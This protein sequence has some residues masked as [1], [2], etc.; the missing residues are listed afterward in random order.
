MNK[1]QMIKKVDNIIN[2]LQKEGFE[3]FS[4]MYGS[5]DERKNNF[6]Q[7]FINDENNDKCNMDTAIIQDGDFYYIRHMGYLLAE[8]FG[9]DL[10][11]F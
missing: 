6:L 10:I 1:E 9:F 2:L 5:D 3:S 4:L 11:E 8:H 7:I